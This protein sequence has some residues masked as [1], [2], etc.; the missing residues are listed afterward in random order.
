MAEFLTEKDRR[1]HYCGTLNESN[2]GETVSVMGWVQRCRDLGALVFVDLRDRTGI[3]QLA[4]DGDSAPEIFEKARRCRA[5][6]V[7]ACHGV[8]RARGEGAVNKNIPTGGIEINVTELKV[9]SAAQTPPIEV[10]DTKRA[11][12]ETALKYRYIDLRRPELQRNIKMRHDL[13]RVAREYYYENGFYEIETPMMIKATPEGA[14]DYLVPS[15]VHKGS[16]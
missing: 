12:D 4:F 14:R 7:I 10:S 11:K 16:F 6:Y 3:L 1:T 13:A 2:I 5:E 9:L 15:R 8:V